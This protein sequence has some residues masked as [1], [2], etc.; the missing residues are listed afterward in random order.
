MDGTV[1]LVSAPGRDGV[2]PRR[3][4]PRVPARARRFHVKRRRP[5]PGP[6][7]RFHVKTER[8][9]A[10]VSAMRL[11]RRSGPRRRRRC[12]RRRR[13]ASR[14]PRRPSSAT[15]RRRPSSSEPAPAGRA[16]RRRTGPSGALRPARDLRRAA[17]PASSRS[18]RARPDGDLAG[19]GVRR[20]REGV[21]P[22]ERARD[23]ERRR[24]AGRPSRARARVYVEFTD[25]ERVRP[26]SSAGTCSATSACSGSTP[27][28]HPLAPV[29]LGDSSRVVVGEPVAAIGSP[30]G[31]QT[32]LSVGVVSAIGRSIDSLTSTVRRRERDPDRRADQPRQLRR[33]AV[34]RRGARDRD[35][36]AD[37]EHLG[38]AEGVGFAIPIDL[39][40]R[41]LDQ[42]LRTGR[43]A[44]AYIGVS[45]QDVTPGIAQ[46][47]DLDAERG[48]LSPAS[49]AARR[50]RRPGFAAARAPRSSTGST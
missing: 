9:L 36:R 7:A 20:R 25:G 10:T 50:P 3:S 12:A 29:P 43:V 42:S 30:F 37:P 6:T 4:R 14:S 17:R 41:S 45:T 13:R 11:W 31:K 48:A 27:A 18:T 16:R 23:H 22:H 21:D 33:A 8:P 46:A 2:H 15:R 1:E 35:Q 34:R 32:S 26:R 24:V 19:L 5:S 39:A 47:F 49:R 44:Y 40:K 38:T 28:D